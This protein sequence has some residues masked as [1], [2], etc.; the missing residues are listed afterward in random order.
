MAGFGTVSASSAGGSRDSE[1]ETWHLARSFRGELGARHPS[2]PFHFVPLFH[3]R[4][5]GATRSCQIYYTPRGSTRSCQ[6]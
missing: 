6:G 3:L 2:T 1:S 4:P 5:R